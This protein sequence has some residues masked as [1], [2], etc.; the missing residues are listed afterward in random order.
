[1]ACCFLTLKTPFMPVGAEA[2]R[3]STG[4][5]PPR[6]PKLRSL[7]FETAIIE[8]YKRRESSVE[9]AAC[10]S[11]CKSMNDP[12]ALHD[13]LAD[14]GHHSRGLGKKPIHGR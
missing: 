13:Q 9:E 3:R 2:P 5:S 11:L 7:P 12:T 8:R 1:M 10:L 14:Q 4:Q 6:E